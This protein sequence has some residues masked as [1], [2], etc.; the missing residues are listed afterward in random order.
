MGSKKTPVKQPIQE[1]K[2]RGRIDRSVMFPIA[3]P[4]VELPADYNQWVTD[5]KQRIHSERLRVALASNAAMVL[6]YW[7]IGQRILEKQQAQG[8]GKKIIDRLSFDLR[9]QFPEMKG[10]SPRNLGYMKAFAAAWPD[11]EI[12][13]RSV[14]KLSWRHNIT[15]L[16]KLKTPE[17]GS[18]ML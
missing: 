1:R 2:Q 16:E 12:L 18:G 9:E 4:K 13:Q 3:P 10:F 6:L 15:L 11:P 17:E 5:L 7:E 8:W 14:A